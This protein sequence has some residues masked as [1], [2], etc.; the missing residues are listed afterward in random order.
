MRQDTSALASLV[1]SFEPTLQVAEKAR[2]RVSNIQK[3]HQSVEGSM[4]NSSQKKYSSFN[5]N[6]IS[7]K[8]QTC[9]IWRKSLNIM[10]YQKILVFSCSMDV[11]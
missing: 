11:M 7:V 5:F 4:D 2:E 10:D 9:F 8:T 3:V 1:R 6:Y